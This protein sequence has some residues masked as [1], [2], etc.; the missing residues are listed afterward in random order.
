MI[1]LFLIS[2]AGVAHQND[3]VLK[4]LQAFLVPIAG[5]GGRL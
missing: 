2:Q 4:K 5:Y 3:N 1:K